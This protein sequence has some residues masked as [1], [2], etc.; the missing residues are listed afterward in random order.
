MC[1][2]LDYHGSSVPDP[3]TI[4]S[5]RPLPFLR[6]MEMNGGGTMLLGRTS[7]RELPLDRITRTGALI[8]P[9]RSK[10]QVDYPIGVLWRRIDESL[11]ELFG[12]S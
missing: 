3:K 4:A 1:D 8:A 10:G 9:K 6:P 5:A 2:V 7:A 12:L 11:R